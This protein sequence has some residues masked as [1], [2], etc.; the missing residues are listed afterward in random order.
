MTD[1]I[2]ALEP[3]NLRRRPR[4][5]VGAAC[6]AVVGAAL[7]AALLVYSGRS[8]GYL[9]MGAGV[10]A[11]IALLLAWPVFAGKA[12]ARVAL[13]ATALLAALCAPAAANAHAAPLAPYLG[14]LLVGIWVA[15]VTLLLRVDA[16]AYFAV[17]R[18]GEV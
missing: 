18:G 12:W 1:P 3:E 14:I 2:P 15:V 10:S 16:R 17:V 9:G 4:A 7:A 5:V 6:G 8:P 13:L 11:G